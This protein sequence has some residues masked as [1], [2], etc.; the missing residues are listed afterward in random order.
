[1][2][3]PFEK[4]WNA[5]RESSFCFKNKTQVNL[6]KSSTIT[7]SYFFPLRLVVLK[8]AKRSM[9]RSLTGLFVKVVFLEW[10]FFLTCFYLMKTPHIFS[11][12]K[13][14]LGRPLTRSRLDNLK[15]VF[16]HIWPTPLCQ[17]H[18]SFLMDMKH[19]SIESSSKS[20]I[21]NFFFLDPKKMVFPKD[22]GFT[23]HMLGLKITS[24]II[25]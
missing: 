15:I 16:I 18:L 14:I 6:E 3:N 4:N 17:I 2:L 19:E 1:M 13:L 7:R 20:K 25:T 24:K 22:D 21:Y 8:G 5:S 23:S 12:S 9:W 10:K 11:L